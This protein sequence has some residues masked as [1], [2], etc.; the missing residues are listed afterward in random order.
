M[1]K[2]GKYWA[3]RV[4]GTNIGNA[5]LE[6]TSTDEQIKGTLR[7]AD[8]RLGI[9]VYEIVGK[10]DGGSLECEG[11]STVVPDGVVG[12]NIHLKSTLTPEGHLKGQWTSTLG[13]GGTFHLFPHDTSTEGQPLPK[14]VE[15]QKQGLPPEQLHTASR[16]IGAV[17]LYAD[18]VRELIGSLARDF[19]QG[20]VIATYRER[21]N[22][23]SRYATDFQTDLSKLGELRYLK[24]YIQEQDAYNITKFAMIELNANGTNEVRVQGVQQSWVIG[25][26]EALAGDVRLRQKTF[27]STFRRFG[28]NI[29]GFIAILT[30]AA[31][32]DLPLLKRFIL[33]LVAGIASVVVY[34]LHAKFIPNVLV[35]LSERKPSRF[36]RILPSILSWLFAVTS[37]V[38]TAIAYGILKGD[39]PKL[40]AW[41][42]G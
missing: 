15:G 27:S 26:A 20:V 31:L 30:I 18:D 10:F 16:Q 28:L 6:L 39:F 9:C 14:P 42:S 8:E 7:F 22:E 36:E 34:Q 17:R 41:F 21:G 11:A 13:G 1:S 5:F 32:P 33:I 23:V 37:G 40:W 24:L 29:N 3:G 12:G 38:V 19:N 25:K 4:F 2:I 35:Y